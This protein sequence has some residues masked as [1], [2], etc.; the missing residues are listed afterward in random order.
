MFMA[1]VSKMLRIRYNWD[2]PAITAKTDRSARLPPLAMDKT[3]GNPS[4]G[5]G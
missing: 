4:R 1:L 2:V 5:N 3:G